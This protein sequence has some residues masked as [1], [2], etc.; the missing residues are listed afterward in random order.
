MLEIGENQVLQVH[1][2]GEEDGANGVD[3]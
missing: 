3:R 1:N 2:D